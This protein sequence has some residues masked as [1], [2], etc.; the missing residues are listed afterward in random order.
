MN[1]D[2]ARVGRVAS[3]DVVDLDARRYFGRV[4]LKAHDDEMSYYRC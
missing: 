3:F 1:Q 2:D 4:M